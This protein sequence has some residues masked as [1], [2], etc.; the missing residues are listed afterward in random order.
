[1]TTEPYLPT[2]NPN[3]LHSNRTKS[4]IRSAFHSTVVE[5]LRTRLLFDKYYTLFF[6]LPGATVAA[7]VCLP[8]STPLKDIL[9]GGTSRPRKKAFL[10]MAK[11]VPTRHWAPKFTIRLEPFYHRPT[12]KVTSESGQLFKNS[13]LHNKWSATR[14]MKIVRLMYLYPG[15][16]YERKRRYIL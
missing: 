14:R 10:I 3:I 9:Q 8:R 5:I 1:M 12:Y 11:H 6:I 13:M 16:P 2:D 4:C 15:N 7:D